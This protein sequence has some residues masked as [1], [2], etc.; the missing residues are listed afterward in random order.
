MLWGLRGRLGMYLFCGAGGGLAVERLCPRD[1]WGERRQVLSDWL[2]FGIARVTLGE[3]VSSGAGMMSNM[4]SKTA[5]SGERGIEPKRSVD[6][7]R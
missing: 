4:L 7:L 6:V 3:G 5:V 1:F 2:A